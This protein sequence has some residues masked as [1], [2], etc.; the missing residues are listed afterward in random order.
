MKLKTTSLLY[1]MAM[2]ISHPSVTYAALSTQICKD[3]YGVWNTKDAVL[4][5][6]GPFY[7]HVMFEGDFC[8]NMKSCVET[9]QA[10]CWL[11]I[12]DINEGDIFMYCLDYEVDPGSHACD[13]CPNLGMWSTGAHSG[14]CH[15]CHLADQQGN[16]TYGDWENV[17]DNRI[18]RTKQSI[19]LT[20]SPN[21]QWACRITTSGSGYEYG[22]SQN[23]Y[24]T[25]VS[26]S[27]SMSCTACPT[28]G[29]VNGQ[30]DEPGF[31]KITA[32]YVPGPAV[33]GT[34][35]TGAYTHTDDKCYYK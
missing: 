2:V 26:A 24:T 16:V 21:S 31:N 18:R 34:D 25:A 8:H 27:S 23:Y 29:G 32:C 7:S 4:C 3:S 35:T 17:A 6:Y 15:T 5:D 11:Y 10:P 28:S 19:S 9:G 1:L 14:S 20:P 12:S 22:C 13:E 30:T 33:T